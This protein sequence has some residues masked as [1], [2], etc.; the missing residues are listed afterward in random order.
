MRPQSAHCV[1][2]LV[3]ETAVRILYLPSASQLTPRNTV[4]APFS[5]IISDRIVVAMRKRR[6]NVWVPEDRLYASLIGAGVFVP[7][8]ILFA[9]LVLQFVHGPA[10]LVLFCICLFMNGLGVSRPLPGAVCFS[11]LTTPMQGR[12]RHE[13]SRGL[14]RRHPTRQERRSH[15][16]LDVSPLISTPFTLNRT[17]ICHFRSFRSVLTSG[18]VVVILPAINLL[19]VLPTYTIIAGV[20]WIGFG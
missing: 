13:P 10:G 7:C 17:H 1:F 18:S 16:C 2:L 3:S 20:S 12:L 15:G 11:Y 8:S 6:G 5:G 4:G 14:Q 9:G 19:G